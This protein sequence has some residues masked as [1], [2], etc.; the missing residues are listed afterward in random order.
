MGDWRNRFA[1]G[2][3]SL[4]PKIQLVPTHLENRIFGLLQIVILFK[5]RNNTTEPSP[6]AQ[7]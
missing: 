3:G 1:L 7:A 6:A 5:R 4:L 2:P